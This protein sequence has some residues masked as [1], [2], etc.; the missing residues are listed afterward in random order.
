M[1]ARDVSGVWQMGAD[2]D[3][4]VVADEGARVWP[5]KAEESAIGGQDNVAMEACAAHSE[6]SQGVY[7]RPILW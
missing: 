2:K 1:G 5:R 7:K 6:V 3:R 4:A